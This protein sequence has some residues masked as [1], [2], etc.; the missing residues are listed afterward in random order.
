MSNEQQASSV[1]TIK[2]FVDKY[3]KF[4]S[5]GNS[6]KILSPTC[7]QQLS[8]AKVSYECNGAAVKLSVASNTQ[9]YGVELLVIADKVDHPTDM[10][11][12]GGLLLAAARDEKAGNHLK[13]SIDLYSQALKLKPG[14]ENCTTDE[15]SKSKFCA[16]MT[17]DGD[18]I[19][20]LN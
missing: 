3:N 2:R 13:V 7:V 9:L 12:A 15:Q 20:T 14:S 5:D 16:A 17:K 4:V 10:W 19:Y 6:P 1:A 18:V 8:D 11:R